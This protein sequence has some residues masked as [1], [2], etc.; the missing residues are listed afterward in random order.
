MD[1]RINVKTKEWARKAMDGTEESVS[2]YRV[3][4]ERLEALL[5]LLIADYHYDEVN[6]GNEAECREWASKAMEIL[7]LS[8]EQIGAKSL[9]EAARKLKGIA[10]HTLNLVQVE[11]KKTTQ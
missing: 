3:V 11:I 10:E 4:L 9:G 8:K 5:I 6:K 7:S 2:V 1:T